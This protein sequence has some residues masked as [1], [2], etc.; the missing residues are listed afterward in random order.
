MTL[1]LLPE[2][3]RHYTVIA[4]RLC[5]NQIYCLAR[6][7]LRAFLEA[8]PEA[9]NSTS[10]YEIVPSGLGAGVRLVLEVGNGPTVEEE[11][12]AETFATEPDPVDYCA[13]TWGMLYAQHR[14]RRTI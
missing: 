10:F 1:R 13:W 3:Q 6:E 4:G 14:E 12:A 7:G 8:Y 11:I 2:P 5:Y 9:D